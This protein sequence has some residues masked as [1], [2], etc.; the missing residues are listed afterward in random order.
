MK[1]ALDSDSEQIGALGSQELFERLQVTALFLSCTLSLTIGFCWLERFGYIIAVS[2]GVLCL[3]GLLVSQFLKV[4]IGDLYRQFQYREKFFLFLIHLAAMICP[5]FFFRL[6]VFGKPAACTILLSI[7][8]VML[9][10]QAIDKFF[11][12]RIYA[13]QFM[14]V[15]IAALYFRGILSPVLIFVWFALLLFSIRYAHIAQ[16]LESFSDGGGVELWPALRRGILPIALVIL[17]GIAAGWFAGNHLPR[18]HFSFQVPPVDTNQRPF[19]RLSEGQF[20]VRSLIL[21]ALIVTI[22][23]LLKWLDSKLL[24]RKG[25]PI[26]IEDG[27]NVTAR[28]HRLDSIA[29]EPLSVEQ[30]SGAREKILSAFR[31]FNERLSAIDLGRRENET[32]PDYFERLERSLAELEALKNAGSTAFDQACYGSDEPTL[33]QAD[34]FVALLNGKI[35]SLKHQEP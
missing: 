11:L 20:M 33:E 17:A 25:A 8:L 24:R 18:Y 13:I 35:R 1:F 29:E 28:V 21:F 4:L 14:I 23:I 16:R 5:Y 27:G 22:L 7:V 15:V 6:W 34:R 3:V 32:V 2:T 26:A 19:E 9:C 30:V 10:F 31:Q 12:G